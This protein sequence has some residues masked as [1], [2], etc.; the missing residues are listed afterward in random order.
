MIDPSYMLNKTSISTLFY[1]LTVC[2]SHEES[3]N[4]Q[5]RI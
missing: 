1:C 4:V 5:N 2:M 3:V